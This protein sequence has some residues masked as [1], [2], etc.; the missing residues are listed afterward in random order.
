VHAA[1]KVGNHD[2]IIDVSCESRTKSELGYAIMSVPRQREAPR[3]EKNYRYFDF[4][5]HKLRAFILR[6]ILV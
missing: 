5:Q 1:V 4:K 2:W 6:V 3:N